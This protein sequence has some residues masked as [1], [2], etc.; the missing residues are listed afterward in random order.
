MRTSEVI[1]AR[2]GRFSWPLLGAAVVLAAGVLTAGLVWR[3]WTPSPAADIPAVDLTGA[4]PEV[5]AAYAATRSGVVHAPRS[6]VAWGQYGMFLLIYNFHSEARR[7]LSEA[8]RLDPRNPRWPYLLGFS[9]QLDDTAEAIP[10]LRRAVEVGGRAP[11]VLRL[12]LAEALLSLGQR[13]EAEKEFQELSSLYPDHARAR[14][15]LARVAYERGLLAESKDL[16]ASCVENRF[17]GKEAHALLAQV[18]AD[19]GDKAAADREQRLAD[20]LPAPLPWP[21]PFVEEATRFLVGVDASL[22]SIEQL[23]EQGRLPET[24]AAAQAVVREHPSSYQGWML[25]GRALLLQRDPAAAEQAFRGALAARPGSVDAQFSLG[26]ALYEQKKNKEAEAAFRTVTQL[27]PTSALAFYNLAGCLRERGDPVGA[28]DA[29]RQALRCKP[30][31]AEAH[32]HLGDLLAAQGQWNEAVEHLRYA[33]Q[34][35][36]EDAPTRARLEKL[37]KRSP[38]P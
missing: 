26:S 23:F 28:I 17:T 22:H 30:N 15:G 35:N 25:L 14:L 13:E 5:A 10:K 37:L 31:L 29:Y 21:D 11:D 3:L 33:V 34:L 18:H 20:S 9:L 36:P 32:Q 19:E 8:E 4:E 16:L 2:P 6:A 24:V 7:C 1:P 38:Q 27:K 12:R